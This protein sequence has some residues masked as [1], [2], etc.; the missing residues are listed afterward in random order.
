MTAKRTDAGGPVPVRMVAWDEAETSLAALRHTVF[1]REQG[2]PEALE[3]D[4]ED[5]DCLHF[6]AEPGGRPVG[7]AR[8]TPSGGIGRMAVL[9]EWRG[10]GIG[11]ALMEAILAEARWQGH[12]ALHLNA[13]THAVGFYERFNFRPA[14]GIF[15]DAGIPHRR[16]T[17]VLGGNREEKA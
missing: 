6:L 8:L 14:G 17:L 10:R 3:W 12:R 4:G 2:V 1:V 7:T 15:D 5:G 13:Q 16:M 11:T 9:P